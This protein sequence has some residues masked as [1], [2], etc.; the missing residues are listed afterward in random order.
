MAAVFGVHGAQILFTEVL[1]VVVAGEHGQDLDLLS[2][3]LDEVGQA[4]AGLLGDEPGAQ[5]G[6]LGG[7]AVGAFAGGAGHAGPAA[8]GDLGRRAKAHAVRAH[9]HR[10]V[11]VQAVAHASHGKELDL[12]MH[13]HV[14]ERPHRPAG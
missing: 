6:I 14:L 8:H 1:D 12:A 7:D 2:R 10:L 3:G 9:G 4:V 5:P 11:G 13:A